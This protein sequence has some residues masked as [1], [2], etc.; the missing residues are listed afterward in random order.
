MAQAATTTCTVRDHDRGTYGVL[1]HVE[2]T[3][4]V[5]VGS[6]G[7]VRFPPGA[8][9]YAGAAARGLDA[10]VERLTRPDG[11][12]QRHVDR[13][14]AL[15]AERTAEA[16]PGDPAPCELATHVARLPGALPV[17]G[18]GSTGCSCLSHLYGFLDADPDDVAEGL[19]SWTP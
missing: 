11:S 15:P 6:L 1:L 19:R 17:L 5:E 14:D 7:T 16:F 12:G 3:E 18:F 4:R 8:Y 10:A 9:V 13:L 2:A